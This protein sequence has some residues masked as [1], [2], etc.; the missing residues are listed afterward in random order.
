M[1]EEARAAL[2]E[3]PA[4]RQRRYESELGLTA[5]AARLLAF[6]AGLGDWFEEALRAGDVEAQVLAQWTTGELAAV[7]T[8][9]GDVEPSESNVRPEALAALVG[10]V[11]RKEVAPAAAKQVLE[12]LAAEGGDPAAIVEAEGLGAMGDGDE[13]DT[14]VQAAIDANPGAAEKIREGKQ[15]AIGAII[16][17]VMR[18]T[19]GRAD[20]GEVSRIVREKLGV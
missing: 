2:P 7:L 18:E 12:K 15:Q 13:L 10:M 19:K 8:R 1:V 9:A 20:G 11:S 4:D 16:G 6:R 17:H 14:L 3:L 5:E